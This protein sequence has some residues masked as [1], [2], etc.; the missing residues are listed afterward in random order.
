MS[1][2]LENRIGKLLKEAR[3]KKGYTQLRTA[4][5]AGLNANAYAKMER[6]ER[7]PATTSLIKLTKILDLNLNDLI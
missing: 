6:G 3:Q 4:T 1:T 7:I 2:P 5:E